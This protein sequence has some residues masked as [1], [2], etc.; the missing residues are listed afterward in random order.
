LVEEMAAE[1]HTS[2]LLL[3]L[4]KMWHPSGRCFIFFL[5]RSYS[6]LCETDVASIPRVC[7]SISGVIWTSA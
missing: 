2:M 1:L 6:K 4:E 5:F 7:S 3:W